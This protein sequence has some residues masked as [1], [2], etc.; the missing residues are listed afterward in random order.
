[1][2]PRNASAPYASGEDRM[3]STSLGEIAVQ[4]VGDGP[5]KVVLWPA[6]FTD[7]HIYDRLVDGLASAATFVLI[8]GPG[9]GRSPGVAREFTLGETAAAMLSVMDALGIDRATVGGVS[10]GG[11]VAAEATLKAPERVERLI[12]MNT[13]MDICGAHPKFGDRLVALGARWMLNREVFRNGVARSFFKPESLSRDP[14]ASRSFHA[15]LSRADPVR[16][17]AAVRS[18]ILRGQPLRP[19]LSA[20]TAP[21]LVIS[22]IND[23]LYPL[24]GQASAALRLQ[25]GRF[26]PVEGCHISPIDAPEEV[27]SLIKAFLTEE[28]YR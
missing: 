28:T 14:D 25:D 23:G 26:A 1:M 7:H 2:T 22:G 20:I 6:I 11:M 5:Q 8:D 21:T 4:V 10:W 24:E 19:R 17:S 13:P 9:H 15:M 18:V 27:K 12:L 3:I 16:L